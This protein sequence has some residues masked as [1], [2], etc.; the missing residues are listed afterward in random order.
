LMGFARGLILAGCRRADA[1][2][3]GHVWWL[4]LLACLALGEYRADI[5]AIHMK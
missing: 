4:C 1:L 5:V 3:G 2:R